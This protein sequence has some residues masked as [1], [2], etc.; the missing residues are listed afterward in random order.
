MDCVTKCK[1]SEDTAYQIKKKMEEVEFKVIQLEKNK[2][3][4]GIY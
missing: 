2:T 4:L 3:D 1:N